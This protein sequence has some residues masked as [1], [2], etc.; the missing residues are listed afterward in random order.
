MLE[1][2]EN[3]IKTYRNPFDEFTHGAKITTTTIN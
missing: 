2:K 1:N 3:T